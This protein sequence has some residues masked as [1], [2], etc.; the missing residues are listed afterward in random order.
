MRMTNLTLTRTCIYCHVYEWLYTGFG[1]M[2]GFIGLFERACDYT[3]QFT[4]THTHSIIHSHIS[5][6]RYTVAASNDGRSSSFGFPNYPR[7]QLPASH[8]NS[9]QRLNNSSSLINSQTDLVTH[10]TINWTQLP[11]TNCPAYNIGTDHTENT[12]P[13]SRCNRCRGNMLVCEVVT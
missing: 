3:L 11:L 4:I 8:N 1:L 7:P 10:Q 6:N 9:S 5:I 2:I 13:L 12:V